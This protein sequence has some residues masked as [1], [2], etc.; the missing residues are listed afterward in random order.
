MTP[1]GAAGGLSQTTEIA[2]AAAG[3]RQ[4]SARN[5]TNFGLTEVVSRERKWITRQINQKGV[6]MAIRWRT[7]IGMALLAGIAVARDTPELKSQKEKQSYAIGVNFGQG[8]LKQS[9]E[10]DM[11][12]FSR[13]LMDSLAGSAKLLTDEEVRAIIAALQA[14]VKKKEAASHARKLETIKKEEADFLAANKEKEGVVTLESGLQYKILKAGDGVKPNENDTAVCNYRGT[15]IDGTEFASTYKNNRPITFPIQKVIRGWREAFPLMQTGSKWQLFVPSS[16]AYGEQG[17][18]RKIGPNA[19]LIFE[20]ELISIKNDAGTGAQASKQAD[21]FKADP[22]MKQQEPARSDAAPAA[23]AI[24]VSFKLDPRLSGPTYGGERWVSP[25]TYMGA[26]AQDTVEARTEA[27]DAH[28]RPLKISSTWTASDPEMVTVSPD[29]G[30]RVKI[31]VKRA[32]ESNVEVAS[33]GLSKILSIKAKQHSNGLQ[34]E[35]S[36]K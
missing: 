2:R 11:T 32:G 20:I 4:N 5:G 34:V 6:R 31:T 9:I 36:Q 28:G 27:T 8:L 15:L 21:A 1:G 23:S 3:P 22:A 33:A 14:E 29:E 19:T 16:L 13:G 7:L 18:G 10:L 25:P 30:N 12:S 26:N 35:I 24:N 17:S